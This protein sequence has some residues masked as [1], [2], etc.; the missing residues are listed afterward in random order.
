M[1]R[2]LLAVGIIETCAHGQSEPPHAIAAKKVCSGVLSFL[3]L[4]VRSQPEAANDAGEGR[5]SDK[6][7]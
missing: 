7:D 2:F 5:C 3:K 1:Y 4:P 6:T